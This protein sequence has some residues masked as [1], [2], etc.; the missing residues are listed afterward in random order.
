MALGIGML[1]D[2]SIVVLENIYRH[3]KLG[4]DVKTAA[5]DGTSEMI[6]AVTAS[7]LTT[8]A[9]FLPLMYVTGMTGLL[10]RQLALMVIFSL[11]CSLWWL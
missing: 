8:V 1:F 6:T 10:F 7:T 2:N 5:I 9:V 11:T 3:R 4:K